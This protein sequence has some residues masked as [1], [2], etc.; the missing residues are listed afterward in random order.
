MMLLKAPETSLGS[1]DKELVALV[2][3]KVENKPVSICWEKG[4]STVFNMENVIM[5][6][7]QNSVVYLE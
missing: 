3:L 5:S 1:K 4:N 2:K 7:K 6:N